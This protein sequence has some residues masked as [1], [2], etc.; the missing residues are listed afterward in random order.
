MQYGCI[1]KKL[2]HSFSAEI[3]ERIGGYDYRLCEV[4][5]DGL[6]LFMRSRDFLG[7]NVTIPYKKDVIPYLYEMNDVARRIG[8]VN[9]VVN[10]GGSNHDLTISASTPGYPLTAKKSLFWEPAAPR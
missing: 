9:T 3:H 8:S 4:P 5:E 6:D 2:G 1:A 10:R 7:I